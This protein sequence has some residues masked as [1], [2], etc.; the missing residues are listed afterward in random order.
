MTPGRVKQDIN[1][2]MRYLLSIGLVDEYQEAFELHSNV[3]EITFGNAKFIT[4]ALKNLAYSQVYSIFAENRVF[5]AKLLGGAFL[6]MGYVFGE[7]K[8]TLLKH[9]LA[10]L[11]P[12]ESDWR[13][14]NS[15]IKQME[16][17]LIGCN[18]LVS[19]PIGQPIRFDYDS[20]ETVHV[21]V[22]HPKSHLTIGNHIKC[23][24]PLT[25]ALTPFW[26]V[27]FIL[28]N[29]YSTGDDY[30]L[31]NL[32][33]MTGNFSVTITNAEQRVPHLVIPR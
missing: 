9:R 7:K 6:Q 16:Y 27:H 29:F 10:F 21:D 20:S 28:R 26:F 11:P 30:H 4:S 15:D 23:R 18:S 19:P 33:K 3:V 32:P 12:P 24:I 25:S 13:D 31:S 2:L 22:F 5:N 8:K 14:W 17:E 1:T